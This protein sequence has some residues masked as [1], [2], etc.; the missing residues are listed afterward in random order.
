MVSKNIPSRQQ[1]H[2]S[3]I[4]GRGHDLSQDCTDIRY[5]KNHTQGQ[6]IEREANAKSDQIAQAF[7]DEFAIATENEA[8]GDNK[9]ENKTHRVAT[10]VGNQ[11]RGAEAHQRKDDG[12][13]GHGI[14]DA[15]TRIAGEI[16]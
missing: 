10:D 12:K 5:G 8:L 7:I 11:R 6:Q 4:N 3:C 9:A 13:A 2:A 14:Q 15:A 1:V 16:G